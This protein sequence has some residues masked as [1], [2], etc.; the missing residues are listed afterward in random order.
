MTI[1]ENIQKKAKG[2]LKLAPV[3][4]EGANFVLNNMYINYQEQKPPFGVEVIAYHHKWVDEDFNPNGTR[5][6]FLS[7]DGFTSAFWWDYQDCYETI[8]K[9]HCESNKDFYK[10]HIDN[11]EPEFWFPIPKFSK[12]L[13]NNL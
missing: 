5:I 11:T 8:S 13:N 10:N 12:P 1:Q 3:F 2:F 4:I 7:D 9:L 6:G